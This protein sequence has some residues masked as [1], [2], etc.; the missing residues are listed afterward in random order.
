MNHEMVIDNFILKLER[1][2]FIT[3]MGR[4]KLG[5]GKLCQKVSMGK[6]MM[7]LGREK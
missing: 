7:K 6:V 4:G 5:M 2:K 3:Q 1:K